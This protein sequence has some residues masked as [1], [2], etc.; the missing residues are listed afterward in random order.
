MEQNNII[1]KRE[2][3]SDREFEIAEE[4]VF[5]GT[6]K[7]ASV[8]LGITVRTVETQAKFIYRKIGITKL[9]ELTLWYCAV[10]FNI[11]KQ[12]EVRKKEINVGMQAISKE[13]PRTKNEIGTGLLSLM[14]FA[15]LTFDHQDVFFRIRR[16]RRRV[17]TEQIEIPTN[18]HGE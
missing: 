4:L 14:M 17:E 5:K 7:E 16:Y 3:L 2:L 18:T 1:Y 11:A 15:S 10:K 12:I 13:M 8:G 6:K 9:N